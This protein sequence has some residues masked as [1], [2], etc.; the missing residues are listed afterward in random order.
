MIP[1]IK[2]QASSHKWFT[3]YQEKWLENYWCVGLSVSACGCEREILNNLTEKFKVLI[4]ISGKHITLIYTWRALLT[5]LKYDTYF[6]I[7]KYF[8][9][10]FK[11]YK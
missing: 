4:N 8:T 9:I 11:L 2:R 1:G 5:D 3:V 6:K 7:Y 10:K